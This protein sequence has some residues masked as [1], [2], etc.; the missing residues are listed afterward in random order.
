MQIM[1]VYKGFKIFK[2][3]VKFDSLVNLL[4]GVRS[5]TI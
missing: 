3:G 2:K 5:D 1:T 4:L